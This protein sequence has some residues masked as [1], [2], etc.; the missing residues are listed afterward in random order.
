MSQARTSALL[1]SA[2]EVGMLAYWALAASMA[3]GLVN[4]PK[5]WM[6]SNYEDPVIVAWNWSFLPVDLLFAALGLTG[7]FFKKAPRQLQDV[8]LTLMFC[9]GIMALSFWA[10]RGEFEPFWWSVNL[11]LVLLASFE[12]SRSMFARR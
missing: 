3:A 9:A 6:Y 7:R 8:S 11:W 5:S 4:V 2:T 1:L 10:I 12:L